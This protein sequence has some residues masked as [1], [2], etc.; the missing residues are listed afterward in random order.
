MGAGAVPIAVEQ[1]ETGV[2]RVDIR[3]PWDRW[4]ETLR[5]EG[6]AAGVVGL[7]VVRDGRLL[8]LKRRPDDY[9]PDYWEVPGGHIDPGESLEDAM[10][11]E[12]YEETGMHLKTVRALVGV[13]DYHGEHGRTRQWNFA[14]DTEEPEPTR[15]PEH[16]AYAWAT[17]TTYHRYRVTPEQ[18]RLLE[19]VFG[20]ASSQRSEDR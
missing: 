16:V 15:H 3:A 13:F 12:L 20:T 2:M 19:Q 18:R 5:A 1:S 9:L 7:V 10:R 6:I 8:L 14:V 4:R 11:R 17:E